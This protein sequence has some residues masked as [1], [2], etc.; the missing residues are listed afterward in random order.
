[1][2]REQTEHR[3]HRAHPSMAWT[4]ESATPLI[5]ADTLP[6]PPARNTVSG[7]TLIWRGDFERV[8]CQSSPMHTRMNISGSRYLP[9]HHHLHKLKKR[10]SLSCCPQLAK[11]TFP[12]VACTSTHYYPCFLCFVFPSLFPFFFTYFVQRRRN[13]VIGCL[14]FFGLLLKLGYTNEGHDRTTKAWERR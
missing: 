12:F 2:H 1:M 3:G 10:P 5:P 8:H 4:T 6:G 11:K 13:W 7:R 14:D 9:I